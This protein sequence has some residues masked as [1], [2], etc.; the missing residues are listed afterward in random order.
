MTCSQCSETAC[1]KQGH[2]WLC[3]RHYRMGQMR[4]NAKRHGKTV[5]T[6]EH[7]AALIESC[8]MVCPACDR[9]MNWRSKDGASIVI[10]LQHNRDGSFA[11]ICLGCNTRHHFFQG[12]SYFTRDKTKHPCRDCGE[13]LPRKDFAKDASRPLGIKPYCKKCAYERYKQWAS[14]NREY[15]N[16]KQRSRRASR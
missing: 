15:I 16:Q 5:P 4:A 7:L 1:I 11:V 9:K 3:P 13:E 2:I 14:R 8:K 6:K 10:T 12:D